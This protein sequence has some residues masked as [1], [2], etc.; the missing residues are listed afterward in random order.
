MITPNFSLSQTNSH[1]VIKIILKYV[2][3]SEADF[4]IED[5]EFRFNLSPY[6][7][8]LTFSHDLN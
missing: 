8:C 6:L 2:R 3:I 7:L 1:L 4:F 5:K